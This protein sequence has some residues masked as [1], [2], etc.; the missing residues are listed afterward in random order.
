ME[1]DVSVP[2]VDTAAPDVGS[3]LLGEGNVSFLFGL[4]GV[5]SG[6]GSSWSSSGLPDGE[7]MTV[8]WDA[9]MDSATSTTSCSVARGRMGSGGPTSCVR[10]SICSWIVL[11]RVADVTAVACLGPILAWPGALACRCLMV[12]CAFASCTSN[13]VMR[14]DDA[15]SI[16]WDA[17][18][19]AAGVPMVCCAELLALPATC[20]LWI[21]SSM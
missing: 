16:P 3:V 5:L 14:W 10:R 19:T 20:F 17:A 8:S 7:K 21:K 9:G 12:R 13:W 11:P 1:A 2:C 15:G 4:K 18:C 6:L